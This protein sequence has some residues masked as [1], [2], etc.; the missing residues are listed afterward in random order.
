MARPVLVSVEAAIASG[1]ST[2][3]S[4]VEEMLGM[5]V[6]VVQEPVLEWQAINGN[7][8]YNIL[9][10]FYKDGARWSYSF[11][12]YVFLTRVRSVENA[13]EHLRKEGRLETTAILVERA[14]VTDKDT[15][16]S[17]L[18]E[19]GSISEVEW[20]M[21]ESWW[22]WLIKKT[23]LFSG[24]IYMRT[25]VDTVMQRLSKRNR[26]EEAGISQDYQSKLI[27]KHEQWVANQQAKDVPIII[28]NAD[29]DFL[30][31][32]DHL[33]GICTRLA[34]FFDTLRRSATP[35]TPEPSKRTPKPYTP[36][37]ELDSSRQE[38]DWLES[39]E[40]SSTATMTENRSASSKDCAVCS[41]EHNSASVEVKKPLCSEDVVG[42]KTSDGV[43]FKRRMLQRENSCGA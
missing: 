12:S 29:V 36:V 17:I 41:V 10:K 15:F 26:G 2:L 20:A 23:P 38:K 19:N 40:T 27:T 11:Q 24:H 18:L 6:Y 13:I 33:Q 43:G 21:Y 30:T 25:S 7:P 5:S 37:P 39:E 32:Q 9:D 35:I 34:D 16:G 31:N 8:E 42:L 4:L 3:L 1:K 22:N 28:V 14:F